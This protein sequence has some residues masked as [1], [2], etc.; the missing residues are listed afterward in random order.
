[1]IHLHNNVFPSAYQKN[2]IMKFAGKWIQPENYHPKW[3][4]TDP[5]YQI[6]HIDE[7]SC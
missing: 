5:E 1:M 3:G 2:D 7:I 4:N 6:L